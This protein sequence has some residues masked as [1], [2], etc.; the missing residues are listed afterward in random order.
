MDVCLCMLPKV[1]ALHT[2][3]LYVEQMIPGSLEN[4]VGKCVMSGM[5][6]GHAVN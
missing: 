5:H 3:N 6:R 2:A 4:V 1:E